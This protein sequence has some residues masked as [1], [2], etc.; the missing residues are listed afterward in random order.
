MSVTWYCFFHHGDSTCSLG[1]AD[2]RKVV[3]AVRSSPNLGTAYV[4]TPSPAPHPHV[5]EDVPPMLALELEFANVADCES[6]LR[7]DASLQRLAD[8]SFVRS[9]AGATVSQQGMLRRAYAVADPVSDIVRRVCSYLV[10]YP[11]PAEDEQAWLD[12]YTVKHATLITALP[13][14]RAV[15]VDTPAVVVSK[16]PFRSAKA[17]L[18]NKVV[19]DSAQALSMA[20][21]SPARDALRADV[22]SFPRYTGGSVHIPTETLVVPGARATHG[23]SPG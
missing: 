5:G 1:D 20:L 15:M 10:H 21:S 8:S 6:A 14:V 2:R 23:G 18:R 16:L 3:D 17:L 22:A 11:G 9:L 7:Q 12:H 19:F 4:H 13:G